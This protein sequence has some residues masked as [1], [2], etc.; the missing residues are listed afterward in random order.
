MQQLLEPYEHKLPDDLESASIERILSRLGQT[1]VNASRQGVVVGHALPWWRIV[2]RFDDRSRLEY[3]VVDVMPVTEGHAPV[4][5][6]GPVKSRQKAQDW[7]NSTA[8]TYLQITG[9]F[10]SPTWP[11]E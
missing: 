8:V 6:H 4:V 9:H 10:F 2:A 11:W 7:A 3:V 5:V 1:G